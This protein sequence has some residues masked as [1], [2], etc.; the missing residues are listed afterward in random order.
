M[1]YSIELRIDTGGLDPAT[2][3]EW[4]GMTWN[5]S[6]MYRKALGGI[7]LT[8]D[9]MMADDMAAKLEAGLADMTDPANVEAYKALNPPNG[10]GDYEGAVDFIARFLEACKAH[11][12]AFVRV[13]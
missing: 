1:S 4:P 7:L 9:K 8:F 3:W 11:P 5:L 13:F 10:W 2:V 12:K 6:P